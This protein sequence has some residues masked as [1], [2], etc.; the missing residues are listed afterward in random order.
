MTS[1]PSPRPLLQ[2]NKKKI[3]EAILFL[4][5]E[6]GRQGRYVTTYDVVKSIFVADVAHLNAYGR[7]VTFDNYYAMK[8]G[9]VPS[10]AYAMLTD[11]GNLE[12]HSS[13]EHWPLWRKTPSPED[14]ATVFKYV[15]PKRSANM[16]ALSQTDISALRDGLSIILA[17]SFSATRDM[18]HEYRSY[19]E[20]WEQRGDRSSVPMSYE[21]LLEGDDQGDVISD[22]VQ[23][24]HYA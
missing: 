21:L 23:A 9:P 11:E 10:T 16:N 4:I 24:S 17:Q 3:V 18:T 8:D 5:E 19:I 22:V 1:R 15:Q 6:A 7:P 12:F 20:A 2:A 14:G 13:I